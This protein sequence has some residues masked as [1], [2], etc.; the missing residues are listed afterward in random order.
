MDGARAWGAAALGNILDSI[1]VLLLPV[2]FPVLLPEII[3]V[4]IGKE[5]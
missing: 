5:L 2:H 4:V 3:I 1:I